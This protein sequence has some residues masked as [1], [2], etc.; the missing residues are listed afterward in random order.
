MLIG[1]FFDFKHR[2]LTRFV[3][4]ELGLHSSFNCLTLGRM[5]AIVAF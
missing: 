3:V 4:G 2:P 1:S 5:R